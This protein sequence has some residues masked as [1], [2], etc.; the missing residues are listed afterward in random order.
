MTTKEVLVQKIKEWI[1]Y[2]DEIK[3]LQKQIKEH[4][5][6]KKTLTDNLLDIMKTN[7]IDCFDINNGKLLFCKNKVKQPIN[8]KTL[9]SSL[10][11]YFENTPS[12]NPEK[13][14]EFILENREIKLTE[15]I[16]RK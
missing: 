4:R 3:T 12:I 13:V 1:T 2:D 8:K 10:E 11:K 7:E 6:N 16:K 14:S 15:A 9:L 5:L